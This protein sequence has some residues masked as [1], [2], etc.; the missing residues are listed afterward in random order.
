MVTEQRRH[1]TRY[2]VN[3]TEPPF[4][5]EWKDIN[6]YS[7]KQFNNC[8]TFYTSAISRY[9]DEW[10]KSPA[11]LSW[12]EDLTEAAEMAKD[13]TGELVGYAGTSSTQIKGPTTTED[14]VKFQGL[15]GLDLT[16]YHIIDIHK[17][18]LLSVE[19][20]TVPDTAPPYKFVGWI[21]NDESF[22]WLNQL[23]DMALLNILF[24]VKHE[25]KQ[26]GSMKGGGLSACVES[27]IFDYRGQNLP[28]LDPSLDPVSTFSNNTHI[29]NFI[30][31]GGQTVG[32]NMVHHSKEA[33]ATQP[34]SVDP[35]E[36]EGE[37]TLEH[38][39]T[40]VT[41][42]PKEL[43]IPT[44]DQIMSGDYGEKSVPPIQLE[45]E[46]DDDTYNPSLIQ[47]VQEGQ[48]FATTQEADR[49]RS[50]MDSRGVRY[51]RG[52]LYIPSLTLP[53]TFPAHTRQMA[54]LWANS[55]IYGQIVLM[56]EEL[57]QRH[58]Y[59]MGLIWALE[60]Q[61]VEIDK[62]QANLD[63][64]KIRLSSA[65]EFSVKYQ[66]QINEKMAKL[67]NSR[68]EIG[69]MNQQ[70]RQF[71]HGSNAGSS[72]GTSAP[73]T[74]PVGG[75]PP[76]V[77]QSLR[78]RYSTANSIASIAPHPVQRSSSHPFINSRHQ[79]PQGNQA[80]TSF[81]IQQFPPSG[82][83][84]QALEHPQTSLLQ[85]GGN[86]TTQ[87]PSQHPASVASYQPD[88]FR[89]AGMPI[90]EFARRPSVASMGSM[91]SVYSA[92][93]PYS[94]ASPGVAR[95][96]YGMAGSPKTT[97][98]ILQNPTQSTPAQSEV[99]G[100]L[101]NQMSQMGFNS[102]TQESSDN[103]LGR[104]DGFVNAS[105]PTSN[106]FDGQQDSR[107]SQTDDVDGMDESGNN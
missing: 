12:A 95:N 73:P 94:A 38:P 63:N 102:F 18:F 100:A 9:G 99:P 33:L 66:A 59:L 107:V 16:S 20:E 58:S 67:N 87:A 4:R 39:F 60:Q 47:K 61:S 56:K 106:P 48:A 11:G 22:W 55:N 103:N 17:K 92:T 19:R 54:Y 23:K 68:A 3:N 62:E 51:T 5:S 31:Y 83:P 37:G 64:E 30:P 24:Y 72:H 40:Q 80:Q 43:I 98:V 6:D 29:A 84:K 15:T 85:Y 77:R 1:L 13:E 79:S 69:K 7:D 90:P 101:Y 41:P 82:Q 46:R 88:Q 91:T 65:I 49:I 8:K 34:G 81:P 42:A 27:N 32:N 50:Y 105:S 104:G 36:R 57:S 14:I 53:D 45:M 70:V 21:E 97:G 86:Y 71:D 2:V 76:M 89:P 25:G 26:R 35:N 44:A 78:A 28:E 52:M 96:V 74:T 75:A 10:L 93:S